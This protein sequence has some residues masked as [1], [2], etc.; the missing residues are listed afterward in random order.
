MAYEDLMGT[1]DKVLETY[2]VGGA[3][4]KQRGEQLKTAQKKYTTGAQAGLASRGL[5]GTTIAASIPAAFEQEVGAQ[6]RTET[7]RLRSGQ[8]MQGLLTKAGFLER[9]Q[10]RTLR[11]QIAT[12][13]REAQE[14][15]SALNVAG[16]VHASGGSGG[17]GSGGGGGSASSMINS[18]RS[19]TINRGGRLGYGGSSG[20]TSATGGATQHYGTSGG[21]SASGS[22]GSASSSVIQ[23]GVWSGGEEIV[24]GS[25]GSG[26]P[27]A[28]AGNTSA[29]YPEW[30]AQKQMA[31]KTY[32]YGGTIGRTYSDGSRLL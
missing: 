16:Q 1:I 13:D 11:E 14:R 10:E 32:E 4:E 18:W 25:P 3:F 20:G 2:K 21:F 19:R 9:D 29:E 15:A 7:E 30:D 23:G 5:S 6:F 12:L 31:Y 27:V 17:G 28:Q 26:T 24:P 8:E 22:S